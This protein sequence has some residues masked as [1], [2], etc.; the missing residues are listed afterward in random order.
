M[1]HTHVHIHVQ[2]NMCPHVQACS[3][4]FWVCTEIVGSDTGGHQK[5]F[6]EAP[7]HLLLATMFRGHWPETQVFQILQFCSHLPLGKWPQLKQGP[8]VPS[9]LSGAPNSHGTNR[10]GNV[11]AAMLPFPNLLSSFFPLHGIRPL[12]QAILLISFN[13]FLSLF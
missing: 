8:E 3:S 4:V 1:A 5:S 2:E 9:L 11:F 6:Q 12:L 7:L 10:F 13:Q